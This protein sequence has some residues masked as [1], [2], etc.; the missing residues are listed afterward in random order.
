MCLT[1]KGSS[2]TCVRPQGQSIVDLTW[3]TFK[4][5]PLIKDWR[6]IID[7]ETLSDHRYIGISVFAIRAEQLRN[8]RERERYLRWSTS[9]LDE[10]L[11]AAVVTQLWADDDIFEAEF[12]VHARADRLADL[13]I[14][15]CDF[16]MPLAKINHV[17]RAAYWWSLN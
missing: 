15:A 10:D 17:K 2:S 14:K 5:V 12:S 13:L 8:R 4:A 9:R 16:A 6:V 11:L 1:N 7:T 3:S